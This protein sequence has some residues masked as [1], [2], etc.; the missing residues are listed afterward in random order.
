MRKQSSAARS[1]G[2]NAGLT[3]RFWPQD[4]QS[5]GED[6]GYWPGPIE[7]NGSLQ[8]LSISLHFNEIHRQRSE[9]LIRH[10]E[11]ERESEQ[12]QLERMQ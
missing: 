1:N 4:A 2:P 3:P 12:V 7:A 8:R 11:A 9:L 6:G 10:A 5:K